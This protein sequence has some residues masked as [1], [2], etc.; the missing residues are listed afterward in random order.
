MTEILHYLINDNLNYPNLPLI[1]GNEILEE[2]KTKEDQPFLIKTY[3]E[4]AISFIKKTR[5]N[6]FFVFA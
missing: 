5:K 6:Q 3:T 1:K 4:E 2:I